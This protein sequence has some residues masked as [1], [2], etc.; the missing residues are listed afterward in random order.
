MEVF[1]RGARSSSQD[2]SAAQR[3]PLNELPVLDEQQ[4]AEARRGNV[5]EETYAR[6][7]YAQQLTGQAT[8]R[9]L[10]KFGQWLEAKARDRDS[11]ASIESVALDTL[12]GK[13]RIC[14]KGEAEQFLF[15]LDEE[16][17]DRFLLTGAADLERSIQ[18]VLE[19]FVPLERTAKAS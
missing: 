5:S 14:G 3:V 1:V 11:S 8:L 12:G 19:I 9:R 16:M 7:L 15:D 2:W 6:T 17:I 10:L 18:R 4:K 13:I